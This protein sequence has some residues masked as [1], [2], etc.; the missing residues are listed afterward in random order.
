[1]GQNAAIS[2]S[3]RRRWIANGRQLTLTEH[4]CSEPASPRLPDGTMFRLGW[5]TLVI[6]M[7]RGKGRAVS[8]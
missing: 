4:F 8:L 3:E 7:T 6:G 5:F 1:M 2:K